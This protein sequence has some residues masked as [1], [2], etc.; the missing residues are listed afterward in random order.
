MNKDTKLGTAPLNQLI[1]SM[2]MPAIMA[3]LINALY[4]VIDRMFIGRI[5]DYGDLALTGVGVTFPIITLITAFSS[6]AGS[7]GAPFASNA[8]GRQDYDAAKKIIANSTLLLITF[9]ISLM[10]MAALGSHTPSDVL[11]LFL[12]EGYHSSLGKR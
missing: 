4:N 7:G 2:V 8:L 11:S 9:T 6:F 5:P 12:D 1:F 10:T 3:Q